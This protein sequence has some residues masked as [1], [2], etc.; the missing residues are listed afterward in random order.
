MKTIENCRHFFRQVALHCFVE[1]A[2]DFLSAKFAAEIDS[3]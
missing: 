2:N 3:S 1:I